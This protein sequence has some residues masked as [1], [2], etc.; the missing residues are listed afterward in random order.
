MVGKYGDII[1]E[2][3]DK[4]ILA[5]NDFTQ[6]VTGRWSSHSV[7]GK[8]EKAEFNG[9]GK[10][11]IT[12]KMTLCATLG[13]RP[14]EMLDKLEEIVE[15]GKVDYMVIGGKA[16]GKNRFTITSISEKWDT[17]YSGGELAKASVSVTMEE[18]V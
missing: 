10:R 12:F 13:V 17:V 4:R 18:Y 3:S 8:K 11:K 6:S 7:I 9:P 1:F 15:S 14:R 2:T 5:F 16:I